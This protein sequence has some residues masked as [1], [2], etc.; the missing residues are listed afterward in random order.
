MRWQGRVSY[1]GGVHSAVEL[2]S[3]QWLLLDL[4]KGLDPHAK[5]FK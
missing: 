4:V 2:V 3:F 5:V 1:L